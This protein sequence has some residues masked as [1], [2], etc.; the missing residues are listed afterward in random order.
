MAPLGDGDLGPLPFLVGL[1]VAD[2]HA[3]SV[4]DLAEVCNLQG[5]Q[6]TPAERAREAQRQQRA[7]ALA[8]QCGGAECQYAGENVRGGRGLACAVRPNCAPDPTQRRLH[9]L[10]VGRRL[11]AYVRWQGCGAPGCAPGGESRQSEA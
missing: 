8:D 2:E 5:A 6:F 7:V 3:E 10:G 11:D 1:A 4:R 9:A